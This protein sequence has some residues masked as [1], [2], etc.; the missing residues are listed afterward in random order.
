MMKIEHQTSVHKI[1]L[2]TIALTGCSAIAGI[3]FDLRSLFG[4]TDMYEAP[5]FGTISMQGTAG[6][7]NPRGGIRLH[8][9]GSRFKCRHTA[10]SSSE[11]AVKPIVDVS[12]WEEVY[13]TTEKS[14]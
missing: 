4:W 11:S 8:R 13:S 3:S 10:G 12:A 9:G 1:N 2:G 6:V 5:V 14:H 7:Q